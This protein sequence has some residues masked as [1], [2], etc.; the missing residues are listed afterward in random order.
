MTMY[1]SWPPVATSGIHR[2]GPSVYQDFLLIV[3]TWNIQYWVSQASMNCCIVAVTFVIVNVTLV[4]RTH[5]L[6]LNTVGNCSWTLSRP[7]TPTHSIQRLHHAP[8]GSLEGLLNQLR[9]PPERPS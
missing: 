9:W 1:F 5:F 8:Y 4:L 3:L 2:W 6:R 7:A